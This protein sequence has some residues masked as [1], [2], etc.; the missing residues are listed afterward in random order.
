MGTYP[1]LFLHKRQEANGEDQEKIHRIDKD[2]IRPMSQVCES[3][4]V[5]RSL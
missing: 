1:V 4:I 2:K 5:I 3:K